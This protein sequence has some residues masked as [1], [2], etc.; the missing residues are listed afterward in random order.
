MARNSTATSGSRFPS[1]SD[2]SAEALLRMVL[3]ID[4]A[5]SSVNGLAYLAA[6]DLLGRRLGLPTGL[7]RP[8]GASLLVFAGAVYY[9]AI[10]HPI[11]PTH[12]RLVIAANA[13]WVLDSL[14]ALAGGWLTPTTAGAVW[15]LVQ[16]VAV[17]L[18]AALQHRALASTSSP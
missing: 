13:L 8:V 5:V 14:A 11:R 9:V 1:L 4:A 6:P 15:I 10:R 3:K 18:F 2:V 17:A 7:L 16:A 12:V